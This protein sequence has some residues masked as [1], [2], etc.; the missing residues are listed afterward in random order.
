MVHPQELI[1]DREH[2]GVASDSRESTLVTKDSPQVELQIPV[3]V[4][5]VVQSDLAGPRKCVVCG[6]KM[7][8][9]GYCPL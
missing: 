1:W 9:R 5:S 2:T 3:P 4:A 7:L 8:L 6:T